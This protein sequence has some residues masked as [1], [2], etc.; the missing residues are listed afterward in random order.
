MILIPTECAPARIQRPGLEP[1]NQ[2]IYDLAGL[3][4]LELNRAYCNTF[5][6]G[7]ILVDKEEVQDAAHEPPLAR[8]QSRADAG[9]FAPLLEPGENVLWLK[10]LLPASAAQALEE[11]AGGEV[12]DHKS[13]L[14]VDELDFSELLQSVSNPVARQFLIEDITSI[15]TDFSHA[16]GSRH[17]HAQLSVVSHDKCCKF[18]TDNVTVRLLCTYA[19]PGTEWVRNEDVV[20][21]NLARTDV[22]PETAN[23]SVLRARDVVRHCAAGDLLLLKGEAFDGNRGSG[24][25][26]R[27]PSIAERTLRRL[28]FKVDEQACCC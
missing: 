12:F 10:R 17:L 22:D 28:L 2:E 26:H 16:L 20:R 14:D 9:P 11:V 18:H 4:G 27:S 5:A 15:V 21:K 13:A 6:S 7:L 24:A 23:R 19:G 25:V 3:R 8:L 1:V